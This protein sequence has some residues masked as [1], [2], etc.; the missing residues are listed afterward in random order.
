MGDSS[1]CRCLT[2]IT[3]G[4]SIG[5]RHKSMFLRLTVRTTPDQSY[6]TQFIAFGMRFLASTTT[7][8][9]GVPEEMGRAHGWSGHNRN[10][11]TNQ[12]KFPGTAKSPVSKDPQGDRRRTTTRR[13]PQ[14]TR[15]D[16]KRTEKQRAR[17]AANEWPS[18]AHVPLFSRNLSVPT[19]PAL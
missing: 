18:P 14:T 5:E 12:K 17:Q 1:S 4:L 15:V 16:L 10:Q 9:L 7:A 13:S 6:H 2:L 3:K 19:T 11:I 8:S